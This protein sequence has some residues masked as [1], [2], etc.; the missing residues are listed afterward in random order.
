MLNTKSLAEQEFEI[1]EQKYSDAIVLEF[2][3]EI[4]NL[5]DKFGNS[6]QTGGSAPY[7]A[8]II[9][10]AV[11][12]LCLHETLSELTGEDDEWNDISLYSNEEKGSIFQNNR[13]SALFKDK[14][15]SYY[16]NAI[17]FRSK[18]ENG[19]YTFTDNCVLY[20]ENK[21]LKSLQYIK[22]YPFSPKTFIID[23]V[24]NGEYF[25]V[26]DENQLKDVFDYYDVKK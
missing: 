4:L 2:K 20:N 19:D 9:S 21:K 24:K 10:S 11:K 12:K 23:V 18:D 14:N 26:K 1:L 7:Y 3:D 17:K 8:E 6:G 5:V 16:I 22:N 25:F 13:N 15:G